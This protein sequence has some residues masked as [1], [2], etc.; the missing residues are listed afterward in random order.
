[1]S[2]EFC[3]SVP[4]LDLHIALHLNIL[5]LETL[6]KQTSVSGKETCLML[7]DVRENK[8]CRKRN[9]TTIAP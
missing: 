6:V 4:W 1:M 2:C 5:G 8:N 7:G 9:S 3:K